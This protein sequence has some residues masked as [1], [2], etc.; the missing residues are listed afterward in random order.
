MIELEQEAHV[1]REKAKAKQLRRTRWW[2]HK[3][4]SA[5][6][7]YCHVPLLPEQVTMDHVVALSRGGCS[8]K[9]NIV[10]A[11]HA[12]NQ[13]KKDRNIVDYLLS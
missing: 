3:R 13:N 8:T 5:H 11:C 4:A 6:C 1:K 10:T 7:F 9:S 2:E 12:C